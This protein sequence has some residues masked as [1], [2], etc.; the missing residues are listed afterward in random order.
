M[1]EYIY[2]LFSFIH[3]ADMVGVVAKSTSLNW[4]VLEMIYTYYIVL[5]GMSNSVTIALM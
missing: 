4:S 5:S 2:S 3:N 1:Q